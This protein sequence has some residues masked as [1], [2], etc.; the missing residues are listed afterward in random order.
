[1][2]TREDWAGRTGLEWARREQALDL[3]LGPAGT[4]GLTTLAAKEGEAVL[5]LGCGAG[6]ST[7]V[8]AKAVGSAGRV[9]GIDISPDLL[10]L[11]RDR[12]AGTSQ[13]EILEADAQTHSFVPHQFDALYSRFGSMFFADPPAAFQNLHGT[14]KPG[15]RAVFVAWRD[16]A[17][18][19][20][21]SVPMTFVIDGKANPGPPSG[22]SPFAWADA[23]A[24]QPV[25]E[26]AGFRNIRLDTHEFMAEIAS[27]DDPDPVARAVHFMMR[28]GPMAVRLKGAS[29]SAKA[30]AN[31]FLSQRL[32]RHLTDGAV[33]LRA[34]AW[35]IRAE[36]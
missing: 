20:W 23:N 14:M 13:A 25:L 28:I 16:A 21:A 24:V 7:A 31:A 30:E 11:A 1:M 9:T 10:A 4:A 35:I 29:D 6:A 18:N 5:D 26:G 19:H 2:T 36:A 8:L 17:R 32:A 12:L 33:R 34:S 15:A 3:L 27:G 22:P